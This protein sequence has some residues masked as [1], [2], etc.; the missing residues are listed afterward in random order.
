MLRQPSPA[1]HPAGRLPAPATV[2]HHIDN[3][4]MSP[5]LKPL[6]LPQL[7]QERK[8]YEDQ[9]QDGVFYHAEPDVPAVY[10]NANSSS[11]DITS[12]VTP[13]FST[14]GHFRYSSSSSSLDLPPQ[15]QESPVSPT[16][17][18][19]PSMRQLPDVQEEELMESEV[20][21]EEDD[22]VLANHFGLY[23]CLCKS[24]PVAEQFSMQDLA[25]ANMEPHLQVPKLVSTVRALTTSTG[26][27]SSLATTTSTTTWTFSATATRQRT[28][29][30]LRRSATAPSLPFPPSP[31]A[32]ALVCPA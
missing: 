8:K 20:E 23:S 2:N 21:E 32:S 29:A 10:F 16:V 17:P 25:F 6:L 9:A 11:S 4:T 12:P 31:R 27:A 1:Q 7:V 24:L 15:L 28:R 22:T 26:P 18:P 30:T 14:K 3:T 13:T 19:K 5:R